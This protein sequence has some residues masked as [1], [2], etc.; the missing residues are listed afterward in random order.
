MLEQGSN[1]SRGY[2]LLEEGGGDLKDEE[3]A[4]RLT[5]VEVVEFESVG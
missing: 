1:S 2:T 4:D 5:N 3:V